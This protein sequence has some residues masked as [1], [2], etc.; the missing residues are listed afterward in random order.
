MA[1]AL[2]WSLWL[3][4]AFAGSEV[5]AGEGS[6]TQFPGLLGPAVAAFVITG[7]T[8]GPGGLR[9][10]V[11]RRG[12]WQVQ[13]RWYAAVAALWTL[14]RADFSVNMT[15]ATTAGSG[16]IAP[17]V[18]GFV[19]AWAILLVGLDLTA[20]RRGRPSPLRPVRPADRS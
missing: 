2:S 9:N 6:P 1:Y 3:P 10:M 19:I 4:I 14:L 17:I 7:V 8:Q 16:P 20:A 11:R 18:S 13:W 5:V 12:R 15:T